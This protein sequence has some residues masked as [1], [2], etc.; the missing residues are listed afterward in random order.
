MTVKL[1]RDLLG[2]ALG[3]T[4]AIN[5]VFISPPPDSLALGFAGFCLAGVFAFRADERK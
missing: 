4:I 1:A 5:E 3:S 2:L